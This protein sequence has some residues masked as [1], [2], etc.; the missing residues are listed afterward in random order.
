MPSQEP[1]PRLEEM[2]RLLIE[3]YERFSCW[4]QGVVKET[5][6]TLPQMHT[7]EVLG[8]CG[9]LRMKELSEKMGITT[10]ALTVLVDR[11]V[12]AGLVERRPNEQDRRSIQVELTEE[13]RRYFTEHHQH[14]LGLTQ[15]MAAALEPQ[16]QEAFL[17]MLRRLMARF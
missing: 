9:S 5:G 7:L 1:G 6:L 16:E 12:R 15:D 10:G 3:F 2:S 11:V 8:T 13:G 17:D 14:H 4:E